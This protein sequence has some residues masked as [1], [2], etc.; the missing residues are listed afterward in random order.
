MTINLTLF[1]QIFHFLI[2]YAFL[3]K[4]LFKP[5]LKLFIAEKE[6]MAKLHENIMFEEEKLTNKELQATQNW[7]LCKKYFKENLPGEETAS[8]I[9]K[10]NTDTIEKPIH[11]TAQES[12]NVVNTITSD[13]KSK[14][15]Q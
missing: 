13:I 2:A 4:F 12:Q 10:L 15:V 9:T 14:V 6:K 1:L 8:V 3:S 7:S 5:L 11:L